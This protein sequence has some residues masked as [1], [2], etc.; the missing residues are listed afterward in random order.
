MPVII[1]ILNNGSYFNT[2]VCV[3]AILGGAGC[4]GGR[5]VAAL[6][7]REGSVVVVEDKTLSLCCFFQER[8]AQEVRRNK[9]L[10]E[11]LTA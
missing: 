5:I 8:H 1:W 10:R 3:R 11:A 9:E 6:T 2:S 7:A 4:G